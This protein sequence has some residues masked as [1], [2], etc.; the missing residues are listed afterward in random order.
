[1][2]DTL[3]ETDVKSILAVRYKDFMHGFG[4]VPRGSTDKW[5]SQCGQGEIGSSRKRLL[6]TAPFVGV[7]D[8]KV[9]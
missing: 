2:T 6:E 9:F 3:R 1:M 4:V 7:E 5:V 8:A